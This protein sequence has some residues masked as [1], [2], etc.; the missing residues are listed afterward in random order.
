MIL[1]ITRTY[2]VVNVAILKHKITGKYSYVN[3]TKGHICPCIFE[4]P[5]DALD[6]LDSYEEIISWKVVQELTI[7][8]I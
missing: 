3:L 6:D 8:G 4:T 5:Q 1:E 2:D 7:K